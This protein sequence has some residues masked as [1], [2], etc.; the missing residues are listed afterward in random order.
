MSGFSTYTRQ[1]ESKARVDLERRILG[2]RADQ[3]DVARLDVRQ[4]SVLLRLVEAMNL[5]DED[6]RPRAVLRGARSASAMTCLISLIPA[7]TAENS[8]ELRLGHVRR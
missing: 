2:G 8:N 7:S 4:E 1:R 6:D 5:V 3:P